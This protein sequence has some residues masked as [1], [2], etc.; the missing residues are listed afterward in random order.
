VRRGEQMRTTT[1]GSYLACCAVI[2]ALG[3][4]AAAGATG[5]PSVPAYRIAR[6]LA[7]D[8]EAYIANLT[9]S[10]ADF[11]PRSLICL[12]EHFKS[13]YGGRPLIALHVFASRWA[14]QHSRGF[15]KVEESP[16]ERRARAQMHGTYTLDRVRQQEEIE[17]LPS[18]EK[19]DTT[20]IRL[21]ARD[22]PQCRLQID[23]RCLVAMEELYYPGAALNSTSSGSVTVTAVANRAGKV[24]KVRVISSQPAM[25][26]PAI[27][28]L[29]Q[30][31]AANL[32]SWRLESAD[33]ETKMRLQFSYVIV[34]P[35]SQSRLE[36]LVWALPDGVEVRHWPPW[37]P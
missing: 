33:R 30:E 9:V 11:S 34:D 31:T 16:S 4:R 19:A 3:L 7:D 17:I 22:S 24:T 14:A 25:P 27:Q 37:R 18:L 10:I 12:G 20:V 5:E 35:A 13:R 32:K 2:A 6:V 8:E 36:N 23:S 1:A 29:V 15:N 21:P 26:S 28:A